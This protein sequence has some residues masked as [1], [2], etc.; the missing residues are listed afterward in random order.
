MSVQQDKIIVVDVEATCWRGDPPP[1]E[2]NE[3]IE[4]GICVLDIHTRQPSNKRGILVRPQR[5]T[6][7]EFCTQLTTLTQEQVAIGMLFESA[8][9]VLEQEYNTMSY[10]WGSWGNYDRK[11]FQAQCLSFGVV[12]PFSDKHM[13]IKR[14][15]SKLA[16]RKRPVGMSKAA[17][18]IGLPL[19]GRHHRG[20]DDAW[21]IAHILGYLLKKYGRNILREYW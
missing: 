7:S 9:A 1:G 8:C 21:N 19:E 3:I 12:Y 10:L 20:E 6:V 14:L 18:M 16:N 5:S 15:F 2:E 4:I 11:L 13:N 17:E